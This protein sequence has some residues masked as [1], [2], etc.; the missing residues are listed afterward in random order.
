MAAQKSEMSPAVTLFHWEAWPSC[1][2]KGYAHLTPRWHH[3]LNYRFL[4]FSNIHPYLSEDNF[5]QQARWICCTGQNKVILNAMGTGG[6]LPEFKMCIFHFEMEILRILTQ[7]IL[8][9]I[10]PQPSRTG[11]AVKQ[12]NWEW[13]KWNCHNFT[14]P[15]HNMMGCIPPTGILSDKKTS[16]ILQTKRRC[17]LPPPH[18]KC[19]Q[20][21]AS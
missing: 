3:G 11:A 21:I 14:N 18:Q 5:K 20:Q 1:W 2:Q 7:L 12:Q 9:V 19:F 10:T 15:P 17:S 6:F 13:A 16:Q 8:R 4:E